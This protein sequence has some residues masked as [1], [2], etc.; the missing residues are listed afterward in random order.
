M[1]LPHAAF[2]AWAAPPAMSTKTRR[3][4]LMGCVITT[5]IMMETTRRTMPQLRYLIEDPA[6]MGLTEKST[7]SCEICSKE[8]ALQHMLSIAA[9]Y[10]MPGSNANLKPAKLPSFQCPH[11][12]HFGCTHEHALLALM[13][14]LVEHIHFGPHESQGEA[15]TH[16]KLQRIEAILAE[17][18]KE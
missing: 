18:Y 3:E 5:M 16:D 13:H 6:T 2:I 11:I 4:T 14:C 15:F 7:I 1:D 8:D 12:Q 9:I 17:P 10:R